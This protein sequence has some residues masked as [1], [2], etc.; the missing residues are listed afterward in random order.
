M[1]KSWIDFVLLKRRGLL[2]RFIYLLFFIT[3]FSFAISVRN[4]TTA[5][6]ASISCNGTNEQCFVDVEE[7]VNGSPKNIPHC[8]KTFSRTWTIDTTGFTS[9]G[10]AK[11][12]YHVYAPNLGA[13]KELKAILD[14]H[15]AKLKQRVVNKRVNGDMAAIGATVMIQ[16]DGGYSFDPSPTNNK[17]SVYS[18]KV[19][20]NDGGFSASSYTQCQSDF[21]YDPNKFSYCKNSASSTF[22]FSEKGTF[23]Q[24]NLTGKNIVYARLYWGGSIF[25]NWK[26]LRGTNFIPSALN[27]IKGYSRIDF[28]APGESVVTIDAKPE[29]IF[30]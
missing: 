15:S 14:D 28:K 13:P 19:F 12:H 1:A 21:V 8:V 2:L 17:S 24:N 27:Y 16:R 18:E 30:G 22:D 3:T 10:L 11:D 25:Q 26:V 6:K 20:V 23:I 5:E 29:D 7:Y 9:S 4:C